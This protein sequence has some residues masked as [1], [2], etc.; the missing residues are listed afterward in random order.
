MK[1]KSN[2][3]AV[4]LITH[5]G[6]FTS[7]AFAQSG[8]ACTNNAVSGTYTTT[9][10]GWTSAGPAG[11]LVPMMP[12]GIATADADGNWASFT[13]INI[14]GQTVIPKASVTGKTNINPD[15]TGN[16]VY[17]KGTASELNI[18]YVANLKTNEI[19]GLVINPGMVASCKLQLA[20]R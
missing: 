11:P 1:L 7:V 2:I 13:S 10:S 8:P 20:S 6:V 18:N 15:C 5:F 3:V 12:V 14:A 17:N 16:M 4:V 9:C 19:F